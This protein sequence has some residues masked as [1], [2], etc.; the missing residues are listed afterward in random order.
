MNAIGRKRTLLTAVLAA[1][2]CALPFAVT[3]QLHDPR[4]SQ[5]FFLQ[6]GLSLIAIVALA[7]RAFGDRELSIR[8]A[9]AWVLLLA[10][11]TA[12]AAVLGRTPVASLAE[13]LFPL[14]LMFGWF[15]FRPVLRCANGFRMLAAAFLLAGVAVA[16]VGIAQSFGIDPLSYAQADRAGKLRI[17]STLGNPNYVASFVAPLVLLAGAVACSGGL[18]WRVFGGIASVPLLV[19]LVL[20]GGRAG[21]GGFVLGG[22]ATLVLAGAHFALSRRSITLRAFAMGSL[23]LAAVAAAIFGALRFAGYDVAGRVLSSGEI[24]L[25]LLPWHIAWD[26]FLQH[27]LAGI[28]PGRF[29]VESRDT[30]IA[31][32]GNPD[33]AIYLIEHASGRGGAASHLHNEYLQTLVETGLAGLVAFALVIGACIVPAAGRAIGGHDGWPGA[34]FLAGA[35]VCQMAD[36]TFGFPFSLPA[37]G[38][39]FWFLLAAAVS[40][41]DTEATVFRKRLERPVFVAACL[42]VASVPAIAGIASVHQ[43]RA[44][45]LRVRIDARPDMLR[46][47]PRT[48][49]ELEEAWFAAPFLEPSAAALTTHFIARGDHE[50]VDDLFRRM[51]QYDYLGGVGYRQWAVALLNLEREEE[52]LEALRKARVLDPGNPVVAEYLALVLVRQRRF[53]EA[54]DALA[55]ASRHDAIRPNAFYLEGIVRMEQR[56]WAAA[57]HA[58]DRAKRVEPLYT[59]GL[60]F[61]SP[62]LDAL[63][64]EARTFAAS[65]AQNV[66]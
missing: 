27:P 26:M 8:R 19:C 59:L 30:L 39:L 64:E 65:A 38:L 55:D 10:E 5:R 46:A 47:S 25:R 48:V 50:R 4:T 13:A 33:H 41:A 35:L 22:V 1:L 60:F 54:L 62:E 14:S 31:F 12:M 18:A 16:L 49:K 21:F 58:F 28:G 36:A 24:A 42:A 7:V 53:E 43:A 40:R 15:L 23:V 51:E 61:E 2:V 44:V 45:A 56:E 34:A 20:S 17:A 3:A 9:D 29:F 52:A 6:C 63:R 11:T 57:A 66:P 37:S 32:L